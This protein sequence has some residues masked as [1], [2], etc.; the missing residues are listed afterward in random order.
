MSPALVYEPQN[1]EAEINYWPPDGEELVEGKMKPRYLGVSDEHTRKMLI[2]DIRGREDEFTW[3]QQGFQVVRLP[4]KERNE[5]DASW[6]KQHF[7]PELSEALKN[8]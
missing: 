3:E 6:V 4:V 7:Y 2:E 8:M 5:F 1:V